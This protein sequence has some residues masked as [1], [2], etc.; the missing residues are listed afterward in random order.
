MK[1][2]DFFYPPR[3]A[4]N[5]LALTPLQKN[6]LISS[7]SN[8]AKYL[9]DAAQRAGKE[10]FDIKDQHGNTPLYYAVK[11]QCKDAVEMLLRIGVDVN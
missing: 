4:F 7:K 5:P 9:A 6:I 3:K 10:N 1:Q 2:I 11:G 8:N